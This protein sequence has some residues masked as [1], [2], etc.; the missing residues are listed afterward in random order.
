MILIGEVS[1]LTWGQLE[2]RRVPRPFLTSHVNALV[3]R[4]HAVIWLTIAAVVYSLHVHTMNN[5]MLSLCSEPSGDSCDAA[6]STIHRNLHGQTTH[7][8]MLTHRNRAQKPPHS[9]LPHTPHAL[10]SLTPTPLTLTPLSHTHTHTAA[11]DICYSSWR[12]GCPGCGSILVEPTSHPTSP[13]C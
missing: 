6:G 10:T 12:R 1:F 11:M 2:C 9:S 3:P 5:A 13:K 8:G 7:A 4:I